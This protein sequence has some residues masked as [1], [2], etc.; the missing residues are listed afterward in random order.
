MLN[1]IYMYKNLRVFYNMCTE[2]R[3]V[4][5]KQAVNDFDIDDL[6]I[7]E[8]DSSFGRLGI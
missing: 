2:L 1:N 7:V 6:G 5:S 4:S 3:Y 8:N